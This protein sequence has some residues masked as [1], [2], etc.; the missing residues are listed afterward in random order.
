MNRL[1]VALALLVLAF[2]PALVS[3]VHSQIITG[4]CG[5]QDGTV[6]NPGFF[7]SAQ[8]GMG[9]RRA[10]QSAWVFTSDGGA[11]TV[12][13]FN[14]GSTYFGIFQNEDTNTSPNSV[15]S[16][17][18]ANNGG[19]WS[20]VSP[21]YSLGAAAANGGQRSGWKYKT[22]LTTIAAAASTNTVITIPANSL[23]YG[24][25][26]RVVTVIPTCATF[27]VTSATPAKTW[28]IGSGSV[29]CAAGSTDPGTLG[30][31]TVQTAASVI[32]ITPNLVP[33]AGT[34]QVRVTIHYFDV[35]PP[36]L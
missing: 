16:I 24:V 7:F 12:L 2:S 32:T 22:E 34:G 17:Q 35:T 36:T 13:F 11:A 28:N 4:C 25:S 33:G 5:A 21:G 9:I 31:M 19:Y 29:G 27:T 23:V 26:V 10:G 1:V 14:A 6:A 8:P 20:S 18:G 30:G 3:H 15:A